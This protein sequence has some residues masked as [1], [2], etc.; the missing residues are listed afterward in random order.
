MGTKKLQSNWFQ[1]F[2][3]KVKVQAPVGIRLTTGETVAL[4]D[5]YEQDVTKIKKNQQEVLSAVGATTL[6]DNT[7]AIDKA[8]SAKN[9]A[10]GIY[11]RTADP[12]KKR[13]WARRLLV[14]DHALKSMRNM[15]KRMTTA[16]DR[17]EMIKGDIELQLMEAEGRAAEARAYAKAGKQ[18][19]L[20]GQNLVDA[21]SRAKDLKLE[22]TNLEI[23][24]EGAEKVIDSRNPEDLLVEADQLLNIKTSQP[25]IESESE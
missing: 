22:Y 19:R 7:L 10:A 20:A 14:A 12:I 13:E 2:S 17:L 5:I 8:M 6:K 9:N 4:A 25:K 11:R 18:L 21:R 23:T 16:H 24:M 15:R 3:V 1:R